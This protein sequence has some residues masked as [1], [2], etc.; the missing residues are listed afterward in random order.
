MWFALLCLGFYYCWFV[1]FS[2]DR[3]ILN[4]SSTDEM[5]RLCLLLWFALVCLLLFYCVFRKKDAPLQ[6][7]DTWEGGSGRE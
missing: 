7:A 1:Y 4:H 5:N 6:A 3:N 2:Y